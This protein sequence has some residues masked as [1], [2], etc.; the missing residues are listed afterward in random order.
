MTAGLELTCSL[1]Q[2]PM[3]N[4]SCAD[5]RFV[6]VNNIIAFVL[7]VHDSQN[8]PRERIWGQHQR[9]QKSSC[10]VGALAAAHAGP[11]AGDRCGG[12]GGGLRGAAG[13]GGGGGRS[14]GSAHPAE[15]AGACWF[16]MV[17]LG[18]V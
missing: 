13:A 5:Y 15:A 9:E 6:C 3:Q 10:P 17:D 18:L 11:G 14:A 2:E 7:V 8:L 12:G 16:R 1:H 4:R